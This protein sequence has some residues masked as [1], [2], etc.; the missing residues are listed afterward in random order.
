MP[1]LK[2]VKSRIASIIS[3][4]QITKAMKMV[5]ASKLRRAQ[6]KILHIRPYAERLNDILG[7][8]SQGKSDDHINEFQLQRDVKKILII[9]ITSDRGLCGAFNSNIYKA[10]VTHIQNKY[11]KAPS[12]SGDTSRSNRGEGVEGEVTL[13]CIGKKG[14]DYFSKRRYEIAADYVKLFNNLNFIEA[15]KATDHI[16]NGFLNDDFQIVDIIYNEFKNVA[17]QIIRTEQFL[18]IVENSLPHTTKGVDG[19]QESGLAVDYI[20]EPSRK[21]IM[22]ALIPYSLRIRFYRALLESNAAEHGARMTAMSQ[23]TDNA[24]EILKDLRLTYNRTRQAAITKEI[25][26]IV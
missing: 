25:L 4:Q 10:V 11:N 5:A 3:T 24:E 7:S 9:V 15:K 2:E 23:A 17:A 12:P 8:I 20:F 21:Q 19:G 14:W 1:N 22:N 18:P 26:E 13:M 16:F 6:D